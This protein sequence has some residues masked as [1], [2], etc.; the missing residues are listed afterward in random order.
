MALASCGSNA[1]HIFRHLPVG[2]LIELFFTR[3]VFVVILDAELALDRGLY[4]NT[5]S[6]VLPTD[7]ERLTWRL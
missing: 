5:R 7:T 1:S 6:L 2:E 3:W 4:R